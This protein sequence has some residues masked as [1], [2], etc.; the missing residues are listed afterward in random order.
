[1]SKLWIKLYHEIL[2]DPKMGQL[3]DRL[4]RRTIELFLLAGEQNDNGILPT[5]E[6]MAWRLRIDIDTLQIE[7]E[8]LASYR[9][10]TFIDGEWVVTKFCERQAATPSTK[11]WQQWN[12]KKN[13]DQYYSNKPA[14][15]NQTNRLN[16]TNNSLRDIDI[17]IDKDKEKKSGANAPRGAVHPERQELKKY[18]LIKTGLPEPPKSTSMKIMQRLW[19]SP[20]DEILK[21]SGCMDTAQDVVDRSVTRLRNKE[22]TI[23]DP[24]SIIKTARAIHAEINKPGA[25]STFTET[26]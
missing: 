6:D 2:N 15:V 3:S 18:F 11:R 12:E 22:L 26:Y 24:N 25:A 14:N 17:D 10:V 16:P 1:M 20:L 7:L 21:F 4:F 9:I 8:N 23:S 13:K 19:W 5:I